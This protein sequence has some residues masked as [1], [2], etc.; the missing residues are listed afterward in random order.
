M[1]TQQGLDTLSQLGICPAFLFEEGGTGGRR[2]GL[3]GGEEQ[4]LDTL[5]I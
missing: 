5:G 4:G 1:G 2:S 3:D